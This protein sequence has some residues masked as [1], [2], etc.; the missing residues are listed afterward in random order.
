[1]FKIEG[2]D[3]LQNKLDDFVNNAEALDGQ[4]NVLVSG[5][6]T[7]DFVSQ[8]TS[9]S[10]ADEMF[11]ASGFKVETQEDFAAIPDADWDNYIR[12]ISRFDGWQSML[13]AAG[14]EWSKR[15]LGL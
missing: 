3:E 6:L 1:M 8:H 10:S 7:D 12:S 5:L 11:T 9:F 15:K 14:Q 4:H 2:L 13:G